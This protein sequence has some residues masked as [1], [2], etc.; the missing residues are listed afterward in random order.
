MS[1]SDVFISYSRKNSA[2]ARRLIDKLY[3]SG[4]DAWVDWEGIPL[5]APNWWAEIKAGIEGADSF[6]FIISLDSM[7]S[8]VCNLELDY[9]LDLKKRIIPVMYEEVVSRDAFASIADYQPDTAMQERLSGGDPLQIAR[10]NWQRLSHINWIFF[11]ESDEF[12]AA[13]V[14][15]IRTV[16]T[17]LPYVKAHTR[18]LTRALE[19]QRSKQPGDLLLFGKE[20][21]AAE[22]WLA[23]ANEYASQSVPEGKS[24]IVNPL[25]QA[26]QRDYIAAS[27][28]GQKRR[29]FLAGSGVLVASLAFAFA[30]VAALV[31][32]SATRDAALARDDQATATRAVATAIVARGTAEAAVATATQQL[33]E[34]QSTAT[35]IPPTLTQAWVVQDI[36]S[37]FA[38]IM[39]QEND[40][41]ISQIAA[42]DALV[43]RY[44]DQPLAYYVRG[45]VYIEQGNLESA[46]VDFSDAIRLNPN[47]AEAYS[48]RGLARYE[49]GDLESAIADFTDA[50]GLDANLAQAYVNRGTA[51]YN[52]G[53]LESAIADF[54]NAIDLDTTLGEAYYNRAIARYDQSD[55]DGAIADFSDAIRFNSNLAEAYYNR[56][57][58]RYDQGDLDDAISDYN[59]AIRLDTT[60]AEA[61]TN[62]GI[63]RYDQGDLDGAI[64]DYNEAVRLDPT[65]AEAY[66]NRGRARYDQGDLDDAIADFTDAIRLNPNLAVAYSNRGSAYGDQ[67]NLGNAIADFN[68]AI[69]LN[70]NYADAYYNRGFA[71]YQEGDEEGA[72]EDY[73]NAIRLNPNYAEAYVNRGTARYN[74]GELEG[75][76]ADFTDAIRLNQSLAVAYANRALAYFTRSETSDTRRAD[77]EQT[78]ADLQMAETLGYELPNGARQAIAEI[79]AELGL[80]PTPA[81]TVGAGG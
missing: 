36:A 27:R 4:K 31:G 2:F 69:D 32:V 6:V 23:K 20:I 50:I 12:D 45:L 51:R 10:D 76:I 28:N 18:Y 58:A 79:E 13:F 74:Q 67:G 71:R 64:A 38:D 81:A 48:N 26:V 63:A 78:L 37:N 54:T 59:E 47:Y 42:V 75:A 33:F 60:F 21:E 44:A 65:L 39:L 11:R 66:S 43:A 56:G 30:V 53:E 29:R 1:N 49:Q 55:L 73:N 17:D 68:Q 72:I 9:A 19:W 46:I 61:Y 70:P 7:A 40:Q 24:E 3:L 16:E 62:R 5:T 34:V 25:P 41:F 14:A 35:Q 77:L 57:R 52:Q 80:M 8:V 22:A 15:L